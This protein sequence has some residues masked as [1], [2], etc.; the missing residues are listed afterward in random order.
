MPP[1]E[2][3]ILP[4][5]RNPTGMGEMSGPPSEPAIVNAICAAT[6]RRIRRVPIQAEDLV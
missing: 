3:H 1:V 5:T 4:S 6:G 2:V